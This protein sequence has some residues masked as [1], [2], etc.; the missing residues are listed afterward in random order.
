MDKI[1]TMKEYRILSDNLRKRENELEMKYAV[2]D[3]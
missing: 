1:I 2:D 3:I